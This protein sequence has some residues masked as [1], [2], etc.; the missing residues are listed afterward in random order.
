MP[1]LYEGRQHKR[2]KRESLDCAMA[3][4]E[5]ISMGVS[6]IITFDAHDP[7]VQ[8]AIPLSGFDNFMPT[9]QFVKALFTHDTSLKIDK[10]H[11][12][13][14]SPDEGAMNRAVYLANNLGVDMGM[15]YK[16]RDYSRVI[17]GRNPIVAHE[18]LGTSVEGK[19]V[20]IIDD[21]IASGESMLDTAR[22]LKERKAEKV[23]ICCTF[24]LFTAGLEKFD[25]YYQNGYI[26]YVITTNLNYRDPE[27]LE[28]PYYIEANMSKY[29]ASIMDIIN[30]DLSVEK[31]RSSNDKIMELMEKV[32]KC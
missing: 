15:F 30:H 20:L 26:D 31:V 24:G 9:Y 17:D 6:N 22:E 16:R 23:I 7:R 1:F 32:N 11:L 14:I 28:K 10:D 18:F 27:L 2:T 19:T 4:E 12:M 5:L 3:L 21:M 29:L 8:N 25:Q 13:I